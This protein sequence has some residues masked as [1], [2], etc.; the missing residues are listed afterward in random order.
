M[1]WRPPWL[2]F[3]VI[4]HSGHFQEG[5]KESCTYRPS[6]WN[7]G[8]PSPLLGKAPPFESAPLIL[9]PQK[10]WPDRLYLES[11]RDSI[12]DGMTH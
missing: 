2:L 8:L 11:E 4:V 5:N 3:W 12:W 7:L 6:P 1:V 9:L 10:A